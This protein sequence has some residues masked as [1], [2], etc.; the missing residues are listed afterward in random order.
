MS[1]GAMRMGMAAS[2]ARVTGRRLVGRRLRPAWSFKF[3][4]F[5][6]ALKRAERDV[7]RLPPSEQGDEWLRRDLPDPILKQVRIEPAT[8]GG[9]PA[10]W[11]IPT[12][13]VDSAS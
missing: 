1:K 12:S 4:V 11:V 3:E 9:V 13:G 10:E 2:F 8:V 6:D 5:A 7:R